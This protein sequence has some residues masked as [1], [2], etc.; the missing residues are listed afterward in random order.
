[1]FLFPCEDE[2][3]PSTSKR[4]CYRRRST[5]RR[6]SEPSTCATTRDEG[7]QNYGKTE[8]NGSKTSQSSVSIKATKTS[9]GSQEGEDGDDEDDDD[10]DDNESGSSGTRSDGNED[11][12]DGDESYDSKMSGKKSKVSACLCSCLNGPE[13]CHG[14][15]PSSCAYLRYTPKTLHALLS[16]FTLYL[17]D[18]IIISISLSGR[19]EFFVWRRL[20]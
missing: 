1:M 3:Q 6:A 14:N 2:Q 13:M 11:E 9:E 12:E 5:Q 16:W 17:T 20:V 19:S 4:H 10:E 7:K 15:G 8:T 18:I